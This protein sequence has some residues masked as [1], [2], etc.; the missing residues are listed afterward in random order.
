[1]SGMRKDTSVYLDSSLGLKARVVRL[2]WS[3]RRGERGR[4]RREGRDGSEERLPLNLRSAKEDAAGL[5]R[6]ESVLPISQ[7]RAESGGAGHV[8]GAKESRKG[9]GRWKHLG[10]TIQ[11]LFWPRH[12]TPRQHHRPIISADGFFL[13]T[14]PVGCGLRVTSCS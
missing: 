5:Q 2:F 10:Q 13:L 14:Y 8:D 3:P 6:S 9:S 12:A 4:A 1:M 11:R 7:G